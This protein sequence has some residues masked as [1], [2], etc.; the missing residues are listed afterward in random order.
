MAESIFAYGLAALA[1]WYGLYRF[2]VAIADEEEAKHRAGELA[3]DDR[4]RA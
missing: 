2:A 3:W 1:M 4:G